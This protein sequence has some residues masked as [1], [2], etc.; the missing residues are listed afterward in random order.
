MD[1]FW[2]VLTVFVSGI[3]TIAIIATLMSRNA[4]TSTVITSA[5]NAASGLLG[6]ALKPVS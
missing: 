1:E 6:A 2:K 4:H 5:G 3:V